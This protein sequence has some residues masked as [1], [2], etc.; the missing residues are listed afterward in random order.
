L[1]DLDGADAVRSL[2]IAETLNHRR[3]PPLQAMAA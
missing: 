1:A 2:H 3:Q